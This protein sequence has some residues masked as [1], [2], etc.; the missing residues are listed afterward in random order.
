MILAVGVDLVSVVRIEAAMQNPRFTARILTKA[1]RE[2]CD[3][4]EKTAGRWAAKEAIQKCLPTRLRWHEIEILSS[5]APLA[6]V[7]GLPPGTRIH[8]SISHERKMAVA[9][10][11]LESVS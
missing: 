9:F 10:A 3:T 11:V 5:P 8:V 2:Y 1:E 7:N 6:R 4:P